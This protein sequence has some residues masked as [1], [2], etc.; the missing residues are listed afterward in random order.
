MLT[1]PKFPQKSRH[2]NWIFVEVFDMDK[3]SDITLKER[4]EATWN[5]HAKRDIWWL[6]K[7]YCLLCPPHSISTDIMV[8][9]NVLTEDVIMQPVE[10]I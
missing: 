9:K 7:V 8:H 10:S 4:R 2:Y 3:I 1:L 5:R 6:S